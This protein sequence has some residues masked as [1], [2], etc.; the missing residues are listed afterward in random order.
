MAEVWLLTL[1][2]AMLAFVLCT[3]TAAL[4]WLIH[5]LL[6]RY[7]RDEKGEGKES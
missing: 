1:Q 6:S 5:K 4:I 7:S 3:A 2:I